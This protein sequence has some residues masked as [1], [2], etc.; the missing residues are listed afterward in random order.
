[1]IKRVLLIIMLICFAACMFTGCKTEEEEEP[2]EEIPALNDLEEPGMRNTV[3]YLEDNNGY[4]VPVMKKIK[5][6]EGIGKAALTE[7]K[8]TALNEAEI[9]SSGLNGVLPEDAEF[10]LAIED[11][12]GMV[13]MQ[14]KDLQAQ[15]ALQE[16]NKIT[17]GSS[18]LLPVRRPQK[19]APPAKR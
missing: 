3:I 11:G 15:S 6:V 2:Y 1:M 10:S 19:E 13:N 17:K 16:T 8:Q 4:V 5:W 7:L 18:N 9:S 14:Q 12:L